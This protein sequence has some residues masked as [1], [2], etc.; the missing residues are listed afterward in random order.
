M[1]PWRREVTRRP[2]PRVG[3]SVLL[4]TRYQSDAGRMVDP[5]VNALVDAL[6]IQEKVV[7]GHAWLAETKSVPVAAGDRRRTCVTNVMTRAETR[8]QSQNPKGSRIQDVRTLSVQ[9]REAE[10]LTCTPQIRVVFHN[11]SEREHHA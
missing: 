7:A 1:C 4:H 10:S 6:T 3:P 2:H 8:F 11:D 9:P 5:S